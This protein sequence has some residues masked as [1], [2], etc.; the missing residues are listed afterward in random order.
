MYLGRPVEHRKR[1]RVDRGGDKVALYWWA[2]PHV[3][4]LVFLIPVFVVCAF[5]PDE[6]F[7]IWRHAQNFITQS[8]FL[9][10]LSAL[11]IFAFGAWLASNVPVIGQRAYGVAAG[12]CIS[13]RHYR[14][15]LYFVLGICVAAYVLLL[16]PALQDPAVIARFLNEDID[17]EQM[18]AMLNRV[19]GVTSLVNLGAL[20]V[21]LLLLQPTLTGVPLSRVDKLMCG[22][23]FI[24]VILRVL[25]WSERL[26]MLEIVI[27]VAIIHLA[28]MHRSRVLIATFP[29]VGIVVLTLFF[30]VTEYFR[31]WAHFYR[32]TGISLTDFV[33]SRTFGYYATALNNGAVIF[34]TFDPL[35]VPYN[36]AEWFFKFPLLNE[37]ADYEANYEFVE[38]HK[39]ALPSFTNPEFTNTSGLF[40][41]INDLGPAMGLAVWLVIGVVSG[42][43]YRGYTERRLLAL[44]LF[45]SWMNGVYEVLRVFYWGGPRYFPVL[46]FLVFAYWFL[47]NSPVRRPDHVIYIRKSRHRM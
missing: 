6:V 5:L 34:T 24:L 16:G 41:P 21:T 22:V 39:I 9:V 33:L 18:R 3:F 40:A 11:A 28:P 2:R 7:L 17:P 8:A 38:R 47:L 32:E 1:T 4:A 26:A 43:L 14:G 35:W 13:R 15:L 20:Y 27:P 10:G 31:S 23:F 19:P 44:L 36:T 30:G 25:L 12:R 29:L 46:V 42:L 37:S 45:P